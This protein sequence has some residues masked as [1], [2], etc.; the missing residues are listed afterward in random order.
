MKDVSVMGP[1]AMGLGIVKSARRGG[2]WVWRQGLTPRR[3][4]AFTAEGGKV[5]GAADNA[6]L[7]RVNARNVGP[8]LPV[9][10]VSEH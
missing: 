4:T 2:F 9:G 8:T 7:A 3:S 6:A 10:C 5:S 1:G